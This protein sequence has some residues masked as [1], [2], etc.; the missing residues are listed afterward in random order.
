MYQGADQSDDARSTQ[1]YLL[2]KVPA[3]LG[4]HFLESVLECTLLGLE[5]DY[6]FEQVLVPA[7]L[8]KQGCGAGWRLK[9]SEDKVELK[10]LL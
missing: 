6:G 9:R 5:P 7:M 10:S 2:V 1:T 4:S 8:S 3:R